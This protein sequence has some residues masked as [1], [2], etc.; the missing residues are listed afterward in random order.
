M[1]LNL[2]EPLHQQFT[3]ERLT[4]LRNKLSITQEDMDHLIDTNGMQLQTEDG[5]W[6]PLFYSP[7]QIARLE[8][9]KAS[10]WH[11]HANPAQ[12]YAALASE[13]TT[14][15]GQHTIPTPLWSFPKA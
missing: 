10:Y 1:A 5:G 6:I 12:H 8:E 7:Q 2:N 15:P 9:A 14:A 4:E 11:E 3:Q 13:W